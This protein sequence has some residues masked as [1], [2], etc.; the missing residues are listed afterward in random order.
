MIAAATALWHDS[1][2]QTQQSGGVSEALGMGQVRFRI[3]GPQLDEGTDADL[4]SA[5][6]FAAKILVLVRALKA[7]DKIANGGRSPHDYKVARL[8]S[9]S[10]TVLISERV[11]PQK[12]PALFIPWS[13]IP[14]FEDCFDAVATGQV[15]RAREFGECT[16]HL[17]RLAKGSRRQFGYAEVWTKTDRVYR[18]DSFLEEQAE[19]TESDAAPAPIDA[20]APERKWFSGSVYGSFDGTVRAVDLRGALPEIKLVLTAGGKQIDCVCT[21][22]HVEQIRAALNRRVRIYGKAIYDGRSGLPRRIEV[23]EI[24]AALIA[25]DFSK[26]RGAFAP[27][28][29][30]PWEGDER[31]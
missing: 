12:R 17:S 8:S 13:G 25:G 11:I 6:V 27:F 24:S 4:V 21:E 14:K 20:I 30:E 18:V 16:R 26:W 5:S 31:D 9:S 2:H 28:E 3:H 1:P 29:I 10:P 23:R 22:E 19:A 7:A 15:S